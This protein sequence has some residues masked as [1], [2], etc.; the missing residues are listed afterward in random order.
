VYPF[1]ASFDNV[2]ILFIGPAGCLSISS[3]RSRSMQSEE[4][5]SVNKLL[6]NDT[7]LTL[8]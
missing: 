6:E 8:L 7:F 2:S 1:K 3:S 5:T 4:S